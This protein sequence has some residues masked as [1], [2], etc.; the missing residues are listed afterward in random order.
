MRVHS[1]RLAGIAGNVIETR[2]SEMRKRGEPLGG[3]NG[4]PLFLDRVD[5]M[6]CERRPY[7]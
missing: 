4:T 5:S 1:A 6:E 3:L 2:G 7:G